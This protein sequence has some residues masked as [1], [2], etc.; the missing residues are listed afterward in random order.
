MADRCCPDD[1]ACH[2]NCLADECFRV[3]T[4]EPLTDYGPEW[5]LE[6]VERF[7]GPS[8]QITIENVLTSAADEG[9]GT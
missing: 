6:D 7:G 2:H 9:M 1:G 3:R 5:K 4:C 8:K